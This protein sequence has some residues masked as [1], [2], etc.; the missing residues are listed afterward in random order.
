MNQRNM[1]TF[2]YALYEKTVEDE[3]DEYGNLVN[4][5]TTLHLFSEG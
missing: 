2:W 4:P 3:T 1:R 5:Y